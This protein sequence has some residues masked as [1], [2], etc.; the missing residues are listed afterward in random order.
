MSSSTWKAAVSHTHSLFVFSVTLV[1]WDEKYE[2]K[3]QTSEIRRC[4][5]VTVPMPVEDVDITLKV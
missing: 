4:L 1:H 5:K 2:Y 3:S